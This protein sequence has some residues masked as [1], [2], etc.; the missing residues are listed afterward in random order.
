M[1]ESARL[2][3]PPEPEP[4]PPSPFSAN[5]PSLHGCTISTWYGYGVVAVTAA[6]AA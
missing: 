2:P 5:A 4:S 6:P 1:M 3:S